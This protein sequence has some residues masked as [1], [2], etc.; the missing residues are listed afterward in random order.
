LIQKQELK[1]LSSSLTND[2]KKLENNFKKKYQKE[3]K[4]EEKTDSINE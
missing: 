3:R 4:A 2:E 1:T